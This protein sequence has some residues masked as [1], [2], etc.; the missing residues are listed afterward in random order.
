M[1]THNK[2]KQ[3]MEMLNT[4]ERRTL[5]EEGAFLFIKITKPIELYKIDKGIIPQSIKNQNK[6][7]HLL[8]DRSGLEECLT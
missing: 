8:F 4:G 5:K 3:W 1:S 6:C 2:Y 7:D